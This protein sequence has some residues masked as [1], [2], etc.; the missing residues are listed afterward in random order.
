MYNFRTYK[1]SKSGSFSVVRVEP[2][3]VQRDIK[4]SGELPETNEKKLKVKIP[5]GNDFEDKIVLESQLLNF[6]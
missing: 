4:S 1:S 3:A 2:E 5:S 6:P